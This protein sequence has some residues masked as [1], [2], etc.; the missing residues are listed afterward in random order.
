MWQGRGSCGAISPVGRARAMMTADEIDV[1]DGPGGPARARADRRAAPDVVP[2]R[3]TGR[4]G[5]DSRD[6]SPIPAGES[7]CLCAARPGVATV[8]GRARYG[9]VENVPARGRLTWHQRLSRAPCLPSL[10]RLSSLGRQRHKRAR[11]GPANGGCAARPRSLVCVLPACSGLG[12]AALTRA[13]IHRA[14][15]ASGGLGRVAAFCRLP[16]CPA[17][18]DLG[19]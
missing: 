4:G 8:G 14:L 3:R 15:L 13:G 12:P 6:V 2:G 9:R 18:G 1:T 7:P 11:A 16:G 5:T 17:V 19:I 10:G